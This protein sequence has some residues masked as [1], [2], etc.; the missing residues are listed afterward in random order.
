MSLFSLPFSWQM[1]G[2]MNSLQI[3]VKLSR[4]WKWEVEITASVVMSGIKIKY[5]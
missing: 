2:V 1:I 4:A 5:V 3:E